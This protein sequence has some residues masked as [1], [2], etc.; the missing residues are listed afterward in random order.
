MPWNS[1]GRA[2]LW[3]NALVALHYGTGTFK[4]GFQ[5]VHHDIWDSDLP[6]SPILY[7]KPYR[8]TTTK[9]VKQRVRIKGKLVTRTRTVR[10]TTTHNEIM[11]MMSKFGWNFIF[12]RKTGKPVVP[13]PEVKVPQSNA[14]DV[15]SVADPADPAQRQRAGLPG[16]AER[17]RPAVREARRHLV[18]ARRRTASRSSSAACSTRTTRRSSS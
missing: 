13:T 11:S 9:Q 12:D 7:E 14:P 18:G 2:N 6:Q 10:T 5:T 3:T 17:R 15:N 8:V 4:W 16:D 1:R